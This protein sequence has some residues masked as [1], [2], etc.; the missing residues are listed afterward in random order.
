[1]LLWVNLLTDGLPALALGVDP[2]SEDIMKRPPKRK[3]ENIID[4]RIGFSILWI[5]FTVMIVMVLLYGRYIG[6]SVEKAMTMALTSFV[7]MKFSAIIPIRSR[8][9]TPTVSNKWLGLAVLSS[10]VAQLALLYSPLNQLFD[11]VPIGLNSWI[12][13]IISS[14]GFFAFSCFMIRSEKR[15]LKW[16]KEVRNRIS[17]T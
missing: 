11:V 2:K 10:I 14:A 6:Q 5:G 12:L 7:F 17:H 3:G 4:E 9:G 15:L 16:L 8:Y 1:M 13:I